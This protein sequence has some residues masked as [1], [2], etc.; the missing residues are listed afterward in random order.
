MLRVGGPPICL[1]A[2]CKWHFTIVIGRDSPERWSHKY[3]F[4]YVSAKRNCFVFR[5]V[6]RVADSSTDKETHIELTARELGAVAFADFDPSQ[7]PEV[8]LH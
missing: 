8:T 2:H 6:H 5:V 3:N 4:I 7:L 1:F